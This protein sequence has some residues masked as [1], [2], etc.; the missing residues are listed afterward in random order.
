[1]K[2]LIKDFIRT[3]PAMYDVLKSVKRRVSRTPDLQYDWLDRFSRSMQQVRFVQIGANDGLHN[4]PV[5]EFI[6]RDRWEGVLIEPLPEVFEL[7]KRNYAG[8]RG[9]QF[10]NAAIAQ[11]PGS[12]SFWTFQPEFLGRLPTEERLDYLRKASFDKQ[13][14]CKFLQGQPDTV[15]REIRVP[16]ETLTDVVQRCLP[17][18][19]DLLVID[20]EGHEPQ[21]I[22]SIDFGAV[23]PKAVFFESHH[24]QDQM[25]ALTGIFEAAGYRM[26]DIGGDSVAVR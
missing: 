14:V 26:Q 19:I 7:L 12:L 2:T 20:A 18:G 8:Q 1:M 15:L 9:L 6:V 17:L 22:R 3:R 16:C 24:I 25:P 11:A 21:I 13:H 23:S 10:L 5:R 4:D